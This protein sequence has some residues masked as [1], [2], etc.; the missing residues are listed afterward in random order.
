M[1]LLVIKNIV[2]NINSELIKVRRKIHA[3][4]ELSFQEVDTSK[5]IKFYL[6]LWGVEYSS[7]WAEH[8]VVGLIKGTAYENSKVIALRADMDALP[9]QE[10]ND[11]EFKSKNAGIMHAC[12]HDIHTTC[13]LGAIYALHQTKDQWGGTI[14]FIFQPGE[15]QLP[16]GAS[17]LIQEGVLKNPEVDA[18]LGLH[19]Q[20]DM[21][22][23]QIGICEGSSMGSSEEIFIELTSSGGHAAMPHLTGDT[24]LTAARLIC[25]IQELWSRIKPPLVPSVVSFGKI[26]TEGGATNVIPGKISIEGTFRCLDPEFREKFCEALIPF[27]DSTVLPF[28]VKAETK[29]VRGYPVLY[30]NVNL[31][32]IWSELSIQYTDNESVVSIPPRLTAEDFARYAE[33]VPAC[34]FRLGTGPSANVHSPKFIVDEAAIPLGSGILAWSAIGFLKNV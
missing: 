3:N 7:G 21:A 23:G 24:V 16:G 11:L 13:L 26:Q 18:I 28:G 25:G 19:V 29:V 27:I 9:I 12:G 10:E 17:I 15:E 4:P 33:V 20:P 32:K 6:D 30:N 8:G 2:S 5:L 31:A 22:V 1:D 34:F 14:K